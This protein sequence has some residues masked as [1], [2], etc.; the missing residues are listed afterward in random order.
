MT[1]MVEIYDGNYAPLD[2]P[3]RAVINST[4]EA[5][6]ARLAIIM[7]KH[8][9]PYHDIPSLRVH[10]FGHGALPPRNYTSNSTHNT[11]PTQLRA[12]ET[13]IYLLCELGRVDFDRFNN[14]K[15]VSFSSSHAPRV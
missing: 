5:L 6:Y 13:I 12:K 15:T 11:H 4:I 14:K 8:S 2:N 9:M 1:P 10:T 7:G 3:R